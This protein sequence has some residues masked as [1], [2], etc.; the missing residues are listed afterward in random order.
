MRVRVCVGTT[1]L[2]IPALFH[3]SLPLPAQDGNPNCMLRS[4]RRERERERVTESKGRNMA[5]EAGE[6]EKNCRDKQE[7]QADDRGI[8]HHQQGTQHKQ[9]HHGR[10]IDPKKRKKRNEH[11]CADASSSKAQE[12]AALGYKP[13]K[14]V[15]AGSRCP[16]GTE[17]CRSVPLFS[18][19][20][21]H[22]R[23][24]ASAEQR[25]LV[26]AHDH[27]RVPLTVSY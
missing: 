24:H 17:L 27:G 11:L 19:A 6:R 13:A 26:H 9:P 21:S 23:V 12:P 4:R 18:G 16:R 20:P 3:P 2:K 15:R 14:R 7:T 5:G 10:A 1:L 25:G 8:T 22:V